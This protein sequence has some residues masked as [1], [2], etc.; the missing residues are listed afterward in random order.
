M[1]IINELRLHNPHGDIFS[2]VTA[3]DIAVTITLV[4]NEAPAEQVLKPTY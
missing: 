4:V 1:L 3:A 2:G